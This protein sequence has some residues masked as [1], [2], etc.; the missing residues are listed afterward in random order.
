MYRYSYLPIGQSSCVA[1]GFSTCYCTTSTQ[2][3]ILMTADVTLDAISS[4][5]AVRIFLKLVQV[6]Q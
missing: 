6:F 3:V 5:I 4:W 2:S 1:A